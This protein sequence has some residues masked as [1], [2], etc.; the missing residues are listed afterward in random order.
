VNR[1]RGV[2]EL[3]VAVLAA[4]GCVLSWLSARTTAVV[5]PVLD[6]QPSTVSTVYDAPMLTLSLLLA[7][8][9][10]VLAVF[11]FTHLRRAATPAD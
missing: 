6:G 2:V 1:R 3:V 9:A 7:A 11:A 10:G 5:A 4:I 8:V